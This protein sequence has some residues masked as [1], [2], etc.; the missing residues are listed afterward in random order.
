MEE[1]LEEYYEKTGGGKR[2]TAWRRST[3]AT[4][5]TGSCSFWCSGFTISPGAIPAGLLAAGKKRPAFSGRGA[6]A[7]E[8]TPWLQE[9][10]GECSL[11]LESIVGRLQEAPALAKGPEVRALYEEFAGGVEG[12]VEKIR[13]LLFSPGRSFLPPSSRLFSAACHSAGVMLMILCLKKG[14]PRFGTAARKSWED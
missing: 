11:Q 1:I 7:L 3:A 13:K 2:F 4:A 6:A 8:Q 5:V 9:L 12:A 14:W 10:Q